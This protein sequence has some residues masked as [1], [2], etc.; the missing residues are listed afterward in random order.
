MVSFELII[1][2][3]PFF[4]LLEFFCKHLDHMAREVLHIHKKIYPQSVEAWYS[5]VLPDSRVISLTYIFNLT[6]HACF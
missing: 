5:L 2:M 3:K 4:K 6:Y 1:Q